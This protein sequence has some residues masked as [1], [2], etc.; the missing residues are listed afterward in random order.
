M[1]GRQADATATLHD[2]LT[3]IQSVG[4]TSLGW[5]QVVTSAAA[6]IPDP[7]P[8]IVNAVPDDGL[9]ATSRPVDHLPVQRTINQQVAVLLGTTTDRRVAPCGG[10]PRR[11]LVPV[12]AIVSGSQAYLSVR[13]CRPG[14]CSS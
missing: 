9:P 2:S 11:S 3:R 13:V 6:T 12:P 8:E 1:S 4:W 14:T 7:P 5:G 10:D